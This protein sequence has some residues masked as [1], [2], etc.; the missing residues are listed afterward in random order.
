MRS[1]TLAG[2]LDQGTGANTL[3]IDNGIIT[4][5]VHQQSGID[6][7]IMNGGRIK[8]LAKATEFDRFLMTGG[9]IVDVFEVTVTLQK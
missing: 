1:G 6:T 5:E 8:S 7:F 3:Q 9:T 2:V 4:G